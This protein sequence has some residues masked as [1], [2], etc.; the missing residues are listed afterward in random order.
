M[1]TFVPGYSGGTATGLHR[2]PYSP[3]SNR[4]PGTRVGAGCYRTE[5]RL[6]PSARRS[7]FRHDKLLGAFEVINKNTGAFSDE[8]EATLQDLSTQVAVALH[9]TRERES[10]LRSHRQLTEQVTKGVTLIGESP[11]MQAMR[12]TNTA[13]SASRLSSS[14]AARCHA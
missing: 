2:L 5:F 8:D 4:L 10:L 12:S 13:W 14:S 9:N 11:A 1:A 7:S 3:D 6:Q